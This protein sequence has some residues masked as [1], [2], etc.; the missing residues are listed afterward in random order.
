MVICDLQMPEM[1]GLSFLKHARAQFPQT[2]IVLMT[3]ERNLDTAIAA[4]RSGIFDYLKKPID[5]QEVVACIERI[6][7]IL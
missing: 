5:P 4:I 3:G 1:D 2:P 6:K 7:K